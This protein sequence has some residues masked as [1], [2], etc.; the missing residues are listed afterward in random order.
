VSR[1]TFVYDTHAGL[2]HTFQIPDGDQTPQGGLGAT[3][4]IFCA[5]WWALLDLRHCLL[6]VSHRSLQDRWWALLGL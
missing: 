5:E 3:I 1:I 4:D 2:Q 6:G